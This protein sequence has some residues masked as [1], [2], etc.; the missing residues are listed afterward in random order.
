MTHFLCSSGEDFISNESR[1]WS[2][3]SP[4]KCPLPKGSRQ[5]S[6]GGLGRGANAEE[7]CCG[8][9]CSVPGNGADGRGRGPWQEGLGAARGPCSPLPALLQGTGIPAEPFLLLRLWSRTALKCQAFPGGSGYSGWWSSKEHFQVVP[10]AGGCLEA[11]S[12]CCQG[13]LNT[14]SLLIWC[15]RLWE[16]QNE[17]WSTGGGFYPISVITV[18]TH[19]E[20]AEMSR[21]PQNSE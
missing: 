15:T 10:I 4:S 21:R 1:V 13:W 17:D 9:L 20:Y 5:G 11:N 8:T 19:L 7:C 18:R 12:F 14:V 3:G 6:G 2:L 16:Q